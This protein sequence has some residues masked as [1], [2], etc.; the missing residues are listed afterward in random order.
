MQKRKLSIFCLGFVLILGMGAIVSAQIPPPPVNQFI[1][2]YDTYWSNL[3]TVDCLGCHVS[4]EAL[5]LRHH[6]LI[7]SKNMQCL[8]C[9]VLIADG[10]G[11][12]VFQDFRTCS[13]CHT[14]TPHHTTTAAQQKNCKACHGS[15]VDNPNDGHYIPTYPMSSVTP[16]KDG[17][18]V[19][20]PA[21]GETIIVQGCE[22][23]HQPDPTAINPVTNRALPIASTYNTHHREGLDCMICHPNPHGV[24][25]DIR[26]CE[27]CHGIKSLH[28]I[29]KNSPATANL[30]TI[31]PGQEDL[32]WGHIGNNWDCNGCH[33]SWVG[34]SA[35]SMSTATVPII[36]NQ[37]NY[38]LSSGKESLLTIN[39]VSFTN[40]S[41]DGNITYNP[42][43]VVSNGTLSHTLQPFST[44]ES[45]IK[46]VIPSLEVGNYDLRVMKED[47]Q[48][49]IAKLTIV[50]PVAVKSA[51]LAKNK[52]VTITGS[53]F[54]VAP[55]TDYTSGLGVFVDATA[56]KIVSWSN[57]KIV[58]T[59]PVFAAG[60]PVT[61]KTVYGKY[62]INMSIAAKKTR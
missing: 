23:C 57:T 49:N 15:L 44:T 61:V 21:T 55:A 10:S 24:P 59:S 5:V 46:V 53:G 45:E 22:A 27:S 18:S 48:S 51:V 30:G 43:V 9:H 29:Q 8:D 11:G 39:G 36:N 3:A 54:G 37:S 32:G 28:N 20:D 13:G 16:L 7:T 56:A 62:S 38:F 2:I 25:L 34:N 6:A 60:K 58:A 31:V 17:R 41:S 1:G 12:F 4:D 19:V 40:S 42:V 47:M 14:T 35:T 33:W 26:V 52:S 50:P